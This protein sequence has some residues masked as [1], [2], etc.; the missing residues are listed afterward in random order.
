MFPNN[1]ESKWLCHQMYALGSSK[2]K[3]EFVTHSVQNHV[4]TCCEAFCKLLLRLSESSLKNTYILAKVCSLKKIKIVFDFKMR[5][6]MD[7]VHSMWTS[8]AFI[9]LF[10]RAFT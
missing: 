2:S 8:Q 7:K 3:Y 5:S 9:K 10:L 4:F 6:I 1:F